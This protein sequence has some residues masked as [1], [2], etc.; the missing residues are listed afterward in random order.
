MSC[1][2]P[3]GSSESPSN[4]R[5]S[6]LHLWVSQFLAL[7]V[8]RFHYT[9]R[10]LVALLV[11]NILPLLL[12]LISLLIAFFLNS[13]PEP[14]PLELSPD[15]FFKVSDYNYIFVGGHQQSETDKFIQTF[16]QL[17]GAGAHVTTD[18]PLECLEG[19]SYYTLGSSFSCPMSD[20]PQNQYSCTCANFTGESICNSIDPVPFPYTKYV[21]VCYNGTGTG[22]RIQKVTVTYD[23]SQPELGHETLTTYL[24]RSKNSFIQERYGGVSFGHARSEIDPSVDETNAA[25]DSAQIFP[26]LATQRAAKVWHSLKGYHAMP[27]YINLMNNGILRANLDQG[28][29]QIEYG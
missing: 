27:T 29:T 26:F 14:P 16:F 4:K 19:N 17:C 1:E 11:Q 3:P 6:L 18:K 22:P 28:Q 9:K 8:K 20:Y 12:I 25:A 5:L 2:D 7:I 21:P 13:V 24:L 15:H 23:P 10:K